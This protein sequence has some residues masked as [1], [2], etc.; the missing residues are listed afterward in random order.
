[1]KLLW[2][3]QR[4][5]GLSNFFSKV[6]LSSVLSRMYRSTALWKR[7]RF[8][9]ENLIFKWVY[10]VLPDATFHVKQLQNYQH[11]S[12]DRFFTEDKKPVFRFSNEI[13]ELAADILFLVHQFLGLANVC[14][15]REITS[16]NVFLTQ[17]LVWKILGRE[18]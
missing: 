11:L 15:T 6:Q 13:L 5:V 8:S 1:M 17:P 12:H 10:L 16:V 2:T 7:T 14:C 3:S 4:T 18:R 9:V